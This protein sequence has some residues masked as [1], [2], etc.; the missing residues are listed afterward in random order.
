VAD[1]PSGT[2]AGDVVRKPDSTAVTT[3]LWRAA[4]LRLDA[5]PHVLEDE[6]G[7]RLLRD[8]ELLASYVGPGA[9]PGP[10]AWL[11]HP[12]M[13]EK[14]RRSRAGAVARARFVEDIVAE[15]VDRGCDQCVILGA[16]LDSFA[17]R[18]L[19]LVRRLCVFEV[20]QPSTQAWKRRRL[21]EL[22]IAAPETLSFVPVDFERQSWVTEIVNAG[23]DRT[24]PAVMSSLGVTNYLS[25]D[26][27]RSMLH[28]VARLAPG[29]L[30]VCGFA[31]PAHLIEPDEREM[32]AD[33][34]VRAAARG[35]PWVSFFS[36][37]GIRR[38]AEGVGFADVNIVTADDLAGRYFAGR[39]DGLRQNSA[40]YLMASV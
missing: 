6:I 27:I 9:A 7:L 15:Q 19:N 10:D 4:H 18:R 33:I 22:G 17:L 37:D 35:H 36:P 26:A 20:D 3:A 34:E 23:F 11:R 32:R 40:A 12:Y 29:S 31:L 16:G 28:D 39:E 2:R 5:P 13:G 1:R 21:H 8:T 30:L 25:V 24:R 38:L 14:F